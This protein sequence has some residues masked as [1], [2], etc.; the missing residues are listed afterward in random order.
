MDCYDE[1]GNRYQLPVYILSA[2]INMIREGD[3]DELYEGDELKD[4]SQRSSKKEFEGK[5][6]NIRIRFSTGED[7]K[8]TVNT[9]ENVASVKRS[10]ARCCP[11]IDPNAVRFFFAGKQLYNKMTLASAK[12][13]S[14]YTIQALV[15]ESSPSKNLQPIHIKNKQSSSKTKKPLS[16]QTQKLVSNDK[17][18]ANH[19]PKHNEMNYEGRK[20]YN[21]D[22]YD[23]VAHNVLNNDKTSDSNSINCSYKISQNFLYNYLNQSLNANNKDQ[24]Y[25][26][27]LQHQAID[28]R[29][30]LEDGNDKFVYAPQSYNET[31]FYHMSYLIAPNQ[32]SNNN[33]LKQKFFSDNPSFQSPTV[34]AQ[35]L[36]NSSLDQIP[37][38]SM[39]NFQNQ[40]K[41]QKQYCKRT[42][43]DN[44]MEINS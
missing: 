8:L 33:N 25:V 24:Q 32:S 17:N 29:P 38:Q 41:C 40:N 28:K 22:T 23:Y 13:E 26:T 1:L 44:S 7:R 31:P 10:L 35:N 16:I 43:Y 37:A 36:G 9:S 19:D 4:K 6:I 20:V 15:V 27:Q 30:V 11:G 21:N 12:V 42:N 3:E 5:Q 34:D 39:H 18:E 14:N 2:P